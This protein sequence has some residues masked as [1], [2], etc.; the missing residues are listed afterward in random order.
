MLF[1]L[2]DLGTRAEL[3]VQWHPLGLGGLE[4]TLGAKEVSWLLQELQSSWWVRI[5]LC[6]VSGALTLITKPS[7]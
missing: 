4:K 6:F 2:L 1:T 7:L 3:P 5:H